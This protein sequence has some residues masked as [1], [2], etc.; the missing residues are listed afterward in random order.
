MKNYIDIKFSATTASRQEF[1][2][3]IL[4]NFVEWRVIN[5]KKTGSFRYSVVITIKDIEVNSLAFSFPCL[6][7]IMT[8]ESSLIDVEYEITYTPMLDK[9]LVKFPEVARKDDPINELIEIIKPISNNLR[10]KLE[11]QETA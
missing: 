10:K 5:Y 3:F 11:T 1:E 4:D 6:A 9:S 2:R 8:S 7:N